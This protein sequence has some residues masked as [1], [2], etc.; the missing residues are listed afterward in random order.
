M[1]A[2]EIITRAAARPNSATNSQGLLNHQDIVDFFATLIPAQDRNVELTNF[3]NNVPFLTD[4]QR[5]KIY[6]D[7]ESY[8]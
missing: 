3:L 7:K 6:G 2:E 4:V 1:T 5:T 8:Q